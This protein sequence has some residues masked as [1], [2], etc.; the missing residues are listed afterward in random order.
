MDPR[1]LL[2][3]QAASQYLFDVYGLS[4]SPSTLAKLAV[5]GMGPAFRRIG[6]IPFYAPTDLDEWV[7][8]ALSAP[9]RSSS[10]TPSATHH[11]AAHV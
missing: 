7:T 11:G 3:R 9:M 2:R 5:I 6:R 4:R 1:K 10:E 8:A